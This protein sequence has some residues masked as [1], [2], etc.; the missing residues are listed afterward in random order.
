MFIACKSVL[1]GPRLSMLCSTP[2][3]GGEKCRAACQA[4][5]DA[6]MKEYSSIAADEGRSSDD[7]FRAMLGKR[8]ASGLGGMQGRVCEGCAKKDDADPNGF[9]NKTCSR[10]KLVY[11]CSATCQ[12]KHWPVHKVACTMKAANKL[13]KLE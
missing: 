9:K 4:E 7:P 8:L 3:C 11:Y 10:C 12:K 6:K 2:Q 13:L 5:A 1:F